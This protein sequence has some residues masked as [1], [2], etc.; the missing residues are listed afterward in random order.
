MWI[1]NSKFSFFKIFCTPNVYAF[2]FCLYWFIFPLFPTVSSFSLRGWKV[3]NEIRRLL[4]SCVFE[5]SWTFFVVYIFIENFSLHA[6]QCHK[7]NKTLCSKGKYRAIESF[8]GYMYV[9]PSR[10]VIML[11]TCLNKNYII[12]TRFMSELCS[13]CNVS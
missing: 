12:S 5:L 7:C 1:N 4:F 13:S 8:E 6:V 9:Y 11:V 2:I 3:Q 10:K